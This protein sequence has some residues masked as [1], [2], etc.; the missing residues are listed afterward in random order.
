MLNEAGIPCGPI[1]TVDKTFSDPQVRTL[2]MDPAV[3]HPMLGEGKIVGQ[4][5][6]L[7]RTP[8]RMR[9]AAPELGAHTEEIL[10]SLGY[11]EQEIRQLH[12]DGVV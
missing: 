4:A 5:V 2:G 9:N 11:G 3:V 10:K 12:D 6:K 1:Y 7:T 8:Q